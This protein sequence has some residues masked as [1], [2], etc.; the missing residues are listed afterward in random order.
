M[1]WHETEHRLIGQYWSFINYKSYISMINKLEFFRFKCL[2]GMVTR[3]HLYWYVLCRYLNIRQLNDGRPPCS[4]T[5]SASIIGCARR[6][7]RVLASSTRQWCTT[8]GVGSR[9]VLAMTSTR[10]RWSSR[11]HRVC[12][13]TLNRRCPKW[14]VPSVAVWLSMYAKLM[15]TYI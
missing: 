9:N 2:L 11:S 7:G 1:Y 5:G 12:L 3:S 13:T 8:S 10:V 14:F 15:A 6:N 4:A